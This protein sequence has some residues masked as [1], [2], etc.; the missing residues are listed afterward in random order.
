MGREEQ[1]MNVIHRGRREFLLASA[2]VVGETLLSRGAEASVARA[3][4]LGE[5][6]YESRH[7]LVGT[8]IDSYAN[9]E[10][11]GKRR[12]IVTYSLFRVE[13]ALDGRGAPAPEITIRTLGGSVGD[14]GQTFHGEAVVALNERATVFVHDAAPNL[15][16]VTA[17][18]QGHYPL[19]PDA[20]GVHRLHAGF[21]S[22]AIPDLPDAAM[23]RLDG[24]TTPE[25][26]E[27]IAREVDV[28]SR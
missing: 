8:A 17:M 5:L 24:R 4:S 28:G 15:Y 13:E 1:G 9:W 25:A 7:V 16:V 26:A 27:L 22:V 20:R 2:S 11:I 6:L 23:R 10:E 18:A 21:T 19:I 3:L 14:I 12:A